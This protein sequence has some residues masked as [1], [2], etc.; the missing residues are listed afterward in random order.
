M[1]PSYLKGA[2]FYPFMDGKVFIIPVLIL[3]FAIQK[4]ARLF[5]SKLVLLLP[6]PV[7]QV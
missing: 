6:M 7:N 4:L 2:S 1:A 5:L 3:K